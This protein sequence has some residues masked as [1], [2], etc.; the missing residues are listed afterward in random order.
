MH[1]P[2]TL[3]IGLAAAL[4]WGASRFVAPAPPATADDVPALAIPGSAYG[5][6]AARTM[7]ASLYAYWHGGEAYRAAPPP[8]PQLPT[9]AAPAPPPPPPPTPGVFSRRRLGATP[10]ESEPVAATAPPAAPEPVPVAEPEPEPSGPLLDRMASWLNALETRRTRRQGTLVR[11]EAHQRFI[12]AST[13]W[14][15]RLA[16]NL[17][18][19]D[20]IL[21]EILHHHILTT[22]QDPTKAMAD[23]RTLSARALA[24]AMSNQAGMMDA[25][26]GLGA[27]VNLM[28]D[29]MLSA[30]PGMP[31]KEDVAK[32]WDTIVQCQ[33][34]YHD[35]RA[36]AET[37]GW[38]QNIPA[39][40]RAE[41]EDHSKFLERITI[42]MREQLVASGL[43]ISSR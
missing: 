3:L 39:I 34:R 38:W 4:S 14:R 36:A 21:Y 15:L 29:L 19:G 12:N 6:L 37:E 43:V 22:S 24:H 5:S 40:R 11:S 27:A 31:A 20:P 9:S 23:V 7:R 30:R 2:H 42:K 35:I 41:I 18:P 13:G 1:V 28:N 33:Q 10:P 25:L 17:D 8:T 32:V 26:T 16:T